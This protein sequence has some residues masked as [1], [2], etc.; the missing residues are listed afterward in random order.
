MTKILRMSERLLI[1]TTPIFVC[2]Y[3]FLSLH[4]LIMHAARLE[5]QKSERVSIFFSSMREASCSSCCAVIPSVRKET[6]FSIPFSN[7]FN[8]S[9]GS[10]TKLTL[11]HSIRVEDHR[12]GIEARHSAVCVFDP[13]LE[14]FMQSLDRVRRADRFPLAF[15]EPCEGEEL[16]A[17]LVQVSAA[18]LAD[19]LLALRRS[20]TSC[21]RR[22]YPCTR[23]PSAGRERG[24]YWLKKV[25]QAR[26]PRRIII[27]RRLEL[28]GIPAPI[29]PRDS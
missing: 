25:I 7:A 1:G 6:T 16:V 11:G 14:L 13:S 4:N 8:T 26:Q 27:K 3:R 15:R 21:R 17:G 28:R 29:K 12:V 18:P 10:R 23:R 19:E 2:V 9:S 24:K 22:S 20:P 5:A